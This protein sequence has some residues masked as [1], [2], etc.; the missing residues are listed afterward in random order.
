[1]SFTQTIE[2]TA[3]DEQAL[4]DHMAAWHGEQHGIAPGYVGARI[5][6]DEAAPG[7]YLIAVDFSSAE[8]AARN[9]DR[10]ET[11]AWASKLDE[12]TTGA[13]TFRNFRTVCSTSDR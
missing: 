2:V 11:A 3:A 6:A 13:P 10:P 1:M 8:E 12:L 7:R 9:N 5:L 4:S